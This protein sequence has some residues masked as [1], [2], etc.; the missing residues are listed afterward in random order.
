MTVLCTWVAVGVAVTDGA[1]P[2]GGRVMVVAA[3]AEGV[4]LAVGTP[5]PP[6]VRLI[7]GV[8]VKDGK[9]GVAGGVP[10]KAPCVP[11]AVG[12]AVGPPG[13]EPGGVGVLNGGGRTGEPPIAGWLAGIGQRIR[14]NHPEGFQ[15]PGNTRGW[16]LAAAQGALI[17]AK[18][19]IDCK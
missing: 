14:L 13:V 11:S 16:T 5:V 9:V 17:L 2:V 4:A 7:T 10:V 1:V 12:W 15:E 6:G 3:V 19:A 8:G 18:D